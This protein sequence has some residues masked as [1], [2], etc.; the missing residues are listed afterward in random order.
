MTP[1]EREVEKAKR[2]KA[3]RQYWATLD[4]DRKTTHREK[5]RAGVKRAYATNPGYREA[6]SAA[7]VKQHAEGRASPGE[8]TDERRRKISEAQKGKPRD[9]LTR[10][11]YAAMGKV[12]H[13]RHKD[14]PDYLH[15]LFAPEA[16]ELALKRS[17]EDAKTNP[18][19]G[20]FETNC[21]AVDWY[22]TDPRGVT[23]RF[24][25]LAHFIRKNPHMFSPEDVL[26]PPGKSEHKTRAYG[27]LAQLRITNTK[28]FAS[29]KG[30]TWAKKKK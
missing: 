5:L 20:K 25:N 9:Y 22:L 18:R 21:H 13:E 7:A 12:A 19:R 28:P 24:R 26:V 10:D 1:E 29:W 30:W 4:P 11:D 23:H 3:S 6:V 14:D 8:M 15:Q 2:S 17:A 27:G 16:R